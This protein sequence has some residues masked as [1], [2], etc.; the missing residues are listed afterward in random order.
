FISLETYAGTRQ[1]ELRRLP[2]V[3]EG[4]VAIVITSQSDQL[5]IP[6]QPC[7]YFFRFGKLSVLDGPHRLQH[8][9]FVRRAQQR[10]RFRITLLERGEQR[11]T[12][13]LHFTTQRLSLLQHDVEAIVWQ[14]NIDITER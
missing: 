14:G 2:R 6:I 1:G 7:T 4:D 3:H 11:A 12:Q 9:R 13:R 10:E 5:F 8:F